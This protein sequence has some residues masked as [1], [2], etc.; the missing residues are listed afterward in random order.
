VKKGFRVGSDAS[1][2]A[3]IE[4][5]KV[6]LREPIVREAIGVGKN[7]LVVRTLDDTGGAGEETK[8]KNLDYEYRSANLDLKFSNQ[9]YGQEIKQKIRGSVD[10]GVGERKL[11]EHT[12]TDTFRV[13][14]PERWRTQAQIPSDSHRNT[15]EDLRLPVLSAN[16]HRHRQS[17]LPFTYN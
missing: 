15:L 9:R 3:N 7:R 16:Y 4:F 5:Y 6:P 2:H 10:D 1:Y 11:R 17:L 8:R 12:L 13:A 14:N